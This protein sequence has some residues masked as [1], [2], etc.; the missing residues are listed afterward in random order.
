MEP[1]D[2]PDDHPMDNQPSDAA[3]KQLLDLFTLIFPNMPVM[4]LWHHHPDCSVDVMGHVT[5]DEQ[6]MAML[7]GAIT[8]LKTIPSSDFK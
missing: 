7:E 6:A 4:L 5:D 3:L 1:A 2:H 8:T